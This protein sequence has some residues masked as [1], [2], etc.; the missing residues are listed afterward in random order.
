[1]NETKNVIGECP[2]DGRQWEC[3]CARCGS[4]LEFEECDNCAG[5]GVYGHECGEDTCCCLHPED[6]VPC[7]YC[8]G[9][10]NYPQCLSVST[11]CEANPLPGR[12][13]VKRS[14]P[15]WFVVEYD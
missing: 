3:Q 6:N 1:M 2:N 12:E 15:E 4:S 11:W 13:N 8:G 9:K 7:N 10:G 5:E 14:T